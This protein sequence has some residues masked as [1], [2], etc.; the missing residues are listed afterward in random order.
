LLRPRPLGTGRAASTATGSGK[1]V[2]L[3]RSG[4]H[5]S[6][7]TS[8]G[9]FTAVAASH[10]SAGS[11][12]AGLVRLAHLTLWAPFR[13]RACCPYPA[14]YAGRLVEGQPW[15]PGF[16][17]PFGVPALALGSSCARW[18][19]GLPCGRLTRHRAWTPTGLPRS[20]PTRCDRVGC[21]LYP[22]AAVSSRLTQAHQSA[23]AASQRPAL[24]P[25]GASHLSGP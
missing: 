1:L 2:R 19:M 13:V 5:P 17:L 25:A 15:C 24:H 14:S 7:W 22:G 8:L 16:L 18:G 20:T 23:P 3:G 21:C 12:P 11:G 9:P 6:L 10:L 4:C